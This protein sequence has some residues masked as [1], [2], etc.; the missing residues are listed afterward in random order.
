MIKYKIIFLLA[1][2][3]VICGNAFS[4][5]KELSFES[6]EK[7]P[8][9]FIVNKT[10]F[11]IRVYDTSDYKNSLVLEKYKTKWIVVDTFDYHRA[12]YFK[13]FNYDG[14]VDFGLLDKWESEVCLFNPTKNLYVKSGFYSDASF[15]D[16][17]HTDTSHMQ[18]VDKNEQVYFDY[19][20]Y[21]REEWYSTL[22]QIKNYKRIELGVIDN[23][24]KY[25]EKDSGYITTKV[26]VHKILNNDDGNEKLIQEIKWNKDEEFDYSKYWKNNWQKFLP[27]KN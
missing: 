20:D 17:L 27:Q 1:F 19:L 24:T 4:Q 25:S 10:Q 21:K 6:L 15:D 14:F 23:E 11:R 18:L 12:I 7:V 16:D 26:I 22:F 5:T 3:L 2:V 13:D 9:K 8:Y